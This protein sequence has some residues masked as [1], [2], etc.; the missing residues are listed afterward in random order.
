MFI[1]DEEVEDAVTYLREGADAAAK[2]RAQRLYLEKFSKSLCALIMKEHPDLGVTAQ[3]R[4]AL[5]DQR[6][7]D[8]LEALQ[9]A[10]FEDERHAFKLESAKA[11]IGAWQTTS[12]VELAM[13]L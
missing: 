6:Y 4:E 1:P 2:A 7:L 9:L 10:I 13:K 8:H 5:A 11:T 12:K 3:E